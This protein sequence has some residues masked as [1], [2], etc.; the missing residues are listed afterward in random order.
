MEEQV[1]RLIARCQAEEIVGKIKE[2]E[3]MK[4]GL[5]KSR[6]VVR[7]FLT[8]K[9]IGKL[10]VLAGQKREKLDGKENL[11]ENGENVM[12]FQET[13]IDDEVTISVNRMDNTSYKA[14]YTINN[15]L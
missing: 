7:M 9:R 10:A 11:G 3:K 1:V 14:K 6:G 5:S 15:D 4:K 13:K 12:V 2:E 8:G